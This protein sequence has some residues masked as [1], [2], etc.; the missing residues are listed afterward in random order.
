MICVV[1]LGVG[2][3]H[4]L[5]AF[6]EVDP[7]SHLVAAVRG[8]LLGGPVASGVAW[9]LAWMAGLLLVFVPVALRGYARRT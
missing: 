9:T 7:L 3:L 6:V 8:L 4:W 1:F 2:A 5:R